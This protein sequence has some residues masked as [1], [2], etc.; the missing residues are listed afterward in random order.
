MQ[1]IQ[2]S[3]RWKVNIQRYCWG[4][5]M[6]HR[7]VVVLCATIICFYQI[8]MLLLDGSHKILLGLLPRELGDH[9]KDEIHTVC[10]SNSL[11][12]A[13][14]SGHDV[15]DEFLMLGTDQGIGP[16]P[17]SDLLVDW[18]FSPTYFTMVLYVIPTTPHNT[19]SE[20]CF[21]FDNPKRPVFLV[22]SLTAVS[23]SVL[24]SPTE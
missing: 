19:W 22:H 6:S 20:R 24:L 8:W 14:L 17:T 15:C 2:S 23:S 21:P 5:V 7:L 1:R 13:I 10:H 16:H 3:F 18:F 12:G 11:V 4:M 9:F